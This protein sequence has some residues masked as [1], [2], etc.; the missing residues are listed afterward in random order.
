M[1]TQM[2]NYLSRHEDLYNEDMFWSIEVNR[3]KKRLNIPSC[4]TG[5]AFSIENFPE[6]AM[7]LNNNQLPFG[8]HAWDKHLDFWRPVF[9]DMGF[10]I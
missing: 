4:K 8:C 5:L 1:R 9:K 10:D 3:K 7:R 6:R 2:D